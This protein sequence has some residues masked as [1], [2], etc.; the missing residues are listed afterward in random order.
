MDSRATRAAESR[1][2]P[3]AA[4]VRADDRAART[5]ADAHARR[6]ARSA[7]RRHVRRLRAALPALDG[8]GLQGRTQLRRV[9][10]D[11]VRRRGGSAGAR[12]ALFLWC[13]QGRAGARRFSG[14]RR[15]PAPCAPRAP[16]PRCRLRGS[17]RSS[18]SSSR[19]CAPERASAVRVAFRRSPNA[20]WTRRSRTHGR[21][22]GAPTDQGRPLVCGDGLERRRRRGDGARRRDRRR[23]ARGAGRLAGAATRR[24]GD[25]AGRRGHRTHGGDAGHAC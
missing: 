4:R 8:P 16:W 3:G 25:G 24:L 18:R 7:T 9:P 2:L 1:R 5:G 14:A 6:R 19:R 10:A 17:Q 12:R 15:S 23:F 21:Q 13:R 11:H 22:H 20:D